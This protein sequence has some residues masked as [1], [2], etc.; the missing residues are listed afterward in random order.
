MPTSKIHLSTYPYSQRYVTFTHHTIWRTKFQFQASSEG[1]YYIRLFA[2][3][4]MGFAILLSWCVVHYGIACLCARSKNLELIQNVDIM[5]SSQV[6]F[7]GR[8]LLL[9]IIIIVLQLAPQKKTRVG[10]QT[11]ILC[12]LYGEANK[13]FL[14]IFP[15]VKL[16]QF[17]STLVLLGKEKQP[18]NLDFS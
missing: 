13:T 15:L 4:K 8:F 7:Q 17:H 3:C 18:N 9:L 5:N 12:I 10:D 16:T 2:Y 6:T 1:F 11:H 14:L